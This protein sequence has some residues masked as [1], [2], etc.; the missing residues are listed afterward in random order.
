[1][2]NSERY[3]DLSRLLETYGPAEPL[4]DSV[5]ETIPKARATFTLSGVW[6]PIGLGERD[7]VY[8]PAAR[9]LFGVD[10]YPERLLFRA[11]VTG[12]TWAS[13][14]EDCAWSFEPLTPV[15]TER[16]ERWRRW[17]YAIVRRLPLGQP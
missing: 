15:R 3:T 7:V 2:T 5:F 17:G 11:R 16:A 1:M 4:D 14:T 10:W 8:I 12:S 6:D 13:L 9:R